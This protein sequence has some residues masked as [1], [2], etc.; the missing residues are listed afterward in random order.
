MR[1]PVGAHYVG[2]ALRLNARRVRRFDSPT[3]EAGGPPGQTIH[4]LP[5]PAV[6]RAT[7]PR[8]N[9]LPSPVEK[10]NRPWACAHGSDSA[11]GINRALPTTWGRRYVGTC[12]PFDDSTPPPLKPVGHPAVPAAIG[13]DRNPLTYVRGS[14]GPLHACRGS[15]RPA[16]LVAFHPC[17]A[18]INSRTDPRWWRFRN[19]ARPSQM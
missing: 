8:A 3:A 5:P 16:S 10:S 1:R 7:R 13:G 4:A 11:T 18:P 9:P 6:E 15:D 14:V 2:A 12:V 19:S 17:I